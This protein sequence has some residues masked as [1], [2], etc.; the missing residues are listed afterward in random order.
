MFIY[1]SNSFINTKYSVLLISGKYS[2]W[3]C[4]NFLFNGQTDK[5]TYIHISFSKNFPIEICITYLFFLST[6]I[7]M[8]MW[9]R[10]RSWSRSMIMLALCCCTLQRFYGV[11]HIYVC[12]YIQRKNKCKLFWS[13]RRNENKNWNKKKR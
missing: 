5:Q 9:T 11:V 7:R 13:R 2:S 4:W 1:S 12:T 8:W 6:A 10:S 3:K